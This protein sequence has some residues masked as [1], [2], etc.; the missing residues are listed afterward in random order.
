MP[1]EFPVIDT[2]ALDQQLASYNLPKAKYATANI[3]IGLQLYFNRKLLTFSYNQTT[4][5]DKQSA[6]TTEVEYRSTSFNIGY[7]LTKYPYF[8]VYPY[9]GFKGTGL[10]YLYRERATDTTS[11]A[12]YLQSS[13]KYKEIT[14][15]RAY[16]DVG[17]GISHQW[18]YLVNFRAGYL[19]PLERASWSINN[20]KTTLPNSPAVNYRYYFSLTVGLGSIGSARDVANRY[21]RP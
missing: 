14:T 4:R 3:G 21:N 11:F 12:G 7:S 18:F 19:L 10:N 17:L 8:S 2:K 6:F 20:S 15:S 1:I 16:L 5:K 9:A 13:L